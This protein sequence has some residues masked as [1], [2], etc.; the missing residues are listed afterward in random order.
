VVAKEREK[1]QSW[2]TQRTAL[3]VRIKSLGCA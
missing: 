3:A 1:E 2:R